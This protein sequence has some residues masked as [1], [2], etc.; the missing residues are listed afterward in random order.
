M[1]HLSTV[2]SL[3]VLLLAANASMTQTLQTNAAAGAIS[4]PAIVDKLRE[5]VT[6]RQKLAEANER[7]VQSGKGETDGRYELAL[8]EARLQLAR[9]LG[10]RTEQV[11][12]LKDALK[13]QQRR[14]E[15]AKRRAA[16]GAASPE[17]V[18]TIR[19]AVLE[20]EVRL[21]REQNSFKRP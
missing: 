2:V 7:A 3:A 19:V 10:Q 12:A 9:E 14:L 8:A 13:V 4:D 5:I 11:A 15:D 21:L 17:D 16:V 20:A 1:K 6:I 18:D